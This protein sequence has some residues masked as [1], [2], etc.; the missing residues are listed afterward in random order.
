MGLIKILFRPTFALLLLSGV[1]N[2]QS[3]ELGAGINHLSNGFHL[4]Y[5]LPTQSRWAVGA[6]LRVMVNTYSLNE[7]R[8]NHVYYQNGYASK[9]WEHFGLVGKFRYRIFHY[10][11]LGLQA[12]GNVL[13]TWHS[14]K[15]KNYLLTLP[16]G[17]YEHD[18]FY[19]KPGL[20]LEAT[21]GLNLYYDISSKIRINAASGLGVVL[22]N[23][24]RYSESLVTGRIHESFRMA[25]YQGRLDIEYVG[26]DGLPMMYVGV[27]YKLP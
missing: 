8:Q 2:A 27:A 21:I 6:G 26:L 19:T 1:A 16:S 10:R 9:L 12:S 13:L 20:A 23:Y 25:K 3:I 22:L 7:N 5:Q 11:G 14:L 18:I 4:T 15:A 24:S 17:T